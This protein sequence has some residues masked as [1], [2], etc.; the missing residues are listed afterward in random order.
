MFI[1][2]WLMQRRRTDTSDE[3]GWNMLKII[4]HSFLHLLISIAV[5]LL[6]DGSLVVENKSF[7]LD[8]SSYLNIVTVSVPSTTVT[9][10][11]TTTELKSKESL[12][13]VQHNKINLL[14]EIRTAT[15]PLHQSQSRPRDRQD[16]FGFL[17]SRKVCSI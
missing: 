11:R 6:F 17:T 3:T 1:E 10:V 12:L 2:D 5:P 9:K 7:G 14:Q 15:P 13:F 4:E 8:Q 16:K